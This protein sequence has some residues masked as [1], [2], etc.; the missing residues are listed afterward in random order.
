MKDEVKGAGGEK[1]EQYYRRHQGH[2][3]TVREQEALKEP[4]ALGADGVMRAAGWLSV[5]TSTIASSHQCQ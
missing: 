3:R 2:T 1:T 5:I 4:G